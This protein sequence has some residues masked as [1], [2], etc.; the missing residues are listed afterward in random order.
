MIKSWFGKGVDLK[1]C[2]ICIVERCIRIYIYIDIS[3]TS[4]TLYK[5]CL[6]RGINRN[7]RGD[8]TRSDRRMNGWASHRDLGLVGHNSTLYAIENNCGG[9]YRTL[10]HL[11]CI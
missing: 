1:Q 3:N 9:T 2:G 7:D 4:I 6:C 11:G 8:N 10:L 5:Y